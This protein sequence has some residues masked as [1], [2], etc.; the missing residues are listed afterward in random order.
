MSDTVSSKYL[1]GAGLGAKAALKKYNSLRQYNCS[2]C[3]QF[4]Q[5]GSEV[6]KTPL[7]FLIS[8]GCGLECAISY[9]LRVDCIFSPIGDEKDLS[10]E[11]TQLSR[12]EYKILKEMGK[13]GIKKI[14]AAAST[15]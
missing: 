10:Q 3:V 5:K 15:S 6:Y 7:G 14:L 4:W 8:Q 2:Y 1:F 12:K 9:G 13:A 11:E